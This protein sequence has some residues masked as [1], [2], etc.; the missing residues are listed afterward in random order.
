MRISIV[1]PTYN[2]ARFIERTIRSVLAQRGDFELEY[3]VIDGGSTDGTVEIL[4]GYAGRLRYVSEGDAGPADAIAKGFRAATGEIVAW[5]NSDDVYC[6]GAL[7]RVRASFERAPEARWLCGRCRI[8]DADDREIRRWITRYKNWWLHRY[9]L[10]KLL[11]VNFISQPAIFLR[12]GLIEEVGA[13]DDECRI[14]FDYAY[15]MRIA[16]RYDPLVVEEYLAAFR[17]HGESLSG[18]NAGEQ[19]REERDMA[20][21]YNPGFALVGALHT[22]NYWGIVGAYGVMG[23]FAGKG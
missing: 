11:I 13:P 20:V 22:L 14:A 23:L 7:E 18:R 15:W 4:E 3:V 8:V 5:L 21:K 10:R 6:E 16:T 1:T 2:H 17:A 12:R 9:S 19:F